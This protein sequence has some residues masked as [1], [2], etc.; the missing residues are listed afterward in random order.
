MDKKIRNLEEHVR[1]LYDELET[2]ENEND[3]LKESLEKAKDMCRKHSASN[4]QDQEDIKDLRNMVEEQ[5]IKIS[6][7]RKHRNEI[8][9]RHEKHID[10]YEIEFKAKEVDIKHLQETSK[11]MKQQICD[12][13]EEISE[14]DVKLADLTTQ[15]DIKKNK[16]DEM[17]ST[18]TSLFEE[19]VGAESDQIKKDLL[20]K[21][22]NLENKLLAEERNSQ[23]RRAM[24]EKLKIL[25]SEN[26]DNLEMLEKKIRKVVNLKELSK[27]RYGVECRRKFCHFDHSF[28]FKKVNKHQ[29]L[30]FPCHKCCKVFKTQHAFAH[31]MEEH[32]TVETVE[33]DEP[34]E[35][36]SRQAEFAQET[37]LYCHEDEQNANDDDHEDSESLES[38]LRSSNSDETSNSSETESEDGDAIFFT[39]RCPWQIPK[40]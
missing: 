1:F 2:K 31:H 29:C 8:I 17:K 12:L 15:I 30:N 4:H 11:Q 19:L 27:C 32:E 35:A 18:Q 6:C 7:L 14:K 10:D 40:P 28:V 39:L 33:S 21:V 25:E 23:R 3:D 16:D 9:D 20:D 24:Y 5:R 22:E 34:V 26:K 36:L 38:S 13:K 37:N